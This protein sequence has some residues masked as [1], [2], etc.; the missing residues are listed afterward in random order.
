LNFDKAFP[1]FADFAK[2]DGWDFSNKPGAMIRILPINDS[3]HRL[4]ITGRLA[5]R[6]L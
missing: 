1:G 4:V 5:F 6:V 3:C 2:E